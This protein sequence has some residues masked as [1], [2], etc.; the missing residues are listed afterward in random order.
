M[1]RIMPAQGMGL[2]GSSY[3]YTD[4][5]PKEAGTYSYYLEDI[6]TRGKATLHGPVTIV[7]PAPS[8]V[9]PEGRIR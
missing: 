5:S 1:P 8:R 9:R 3:T 4:A 6:D 7:V 2:S